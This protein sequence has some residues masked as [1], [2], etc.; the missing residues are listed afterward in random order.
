MS[1]KKLKIVFMGT[2]DFAAV[3]LESIIRSKHKIV[4]VVT[5]PDRQS[6]RGRKI[7]ESAVKKIAVSNN[8]PIE[9]PEKLKSPDFHEILKFWD[10]DLFVIVAFRMLPE[11]VWSMP[12]KGTINL[13]A[14]LLP[15]FRGAAPIQRAIMKG[16]RESGATVF[17]LAHKIDTGNIISR[18]KLDIGPNENAGSL[19]DRILGSG[20]KLL[21]ES[22]DLIADDLTKEIP[23]NKLVSGELL[24]ATKIF[25][26]DRRIDWSL[27]TLEIH[28]QIRGLSPYPSAFTTI[29]G[30]EDD[31]L[32]I[33]A[34][35]PTTGKI[36]AGCVVIENSKLIVGTAD[37]SYEITKIQPA[38]KSAMDSKSFINGLRE[39]IKKFN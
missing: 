37:G 20:S 25:K 17:K 9:Q 36:Q 27:N 24:E 31:L 39:E 7:N 26:E 23:Q 1:N 12:E 19:H 13:H 32:K 6:G 2:P 14:S 5:A 16:A 29:S 22:I 30:K 8:L 38:G 28:N 35:I 10:A 21:I 34:G 33:L 4:G 11:V 15:Q 18:V 3:C